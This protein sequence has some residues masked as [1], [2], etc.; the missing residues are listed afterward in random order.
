MLASYQPQEKKVLVIDEFQYLVS[1]NAAYPSIF[2]EA[3]DEI[4]KDSNVMA[5]LCGLLIS[6]MISKVLSRSSPLYGRRT[7]Q[8][9]LQPLRF[10]GECKNY[11]KPVPADV[12]FDL[13]KKCEGV[14]EFQGKHIVYGIFSKSGFEQRLL[15]TT[16]EN[17]D[18]YLFDQGERIL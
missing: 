7:A 18:L 16:K 6:M 2:Q 17:P 13:K 14:T 5:I 1:V 4:L 10:A 12:Y 9:R 8:I 15:D 11:D 3:W